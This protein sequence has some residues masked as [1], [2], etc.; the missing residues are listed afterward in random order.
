MNLTV[1]MVFTIVLIS[2]A[3]LRITANGILKQ[4]LM[5]GNILVNSIQSSLDSIFRGD[6]E[7]FHKGK[8]GWRLTRLV[9]SLSRERGFNT[10]FIFDREGRVIAH[11]E[12]G[13]EGTVF[14]DQD[15]NKA[16]SSGQII[17]KFGKGYRWFYWGVSDELVISAPIRLGLKIVGGMRANLSLKDLQESIINTQKIIFLYIVFD[18]AVIIMFGGFLLS[19]SVVRPIERLLEATDKMGGGDFSQ[20]MEDSGVNEISKLF[21]SFNRMSMRLEEHVL[22]LEGANVELKQIR[23]EVIR[24]EKL[25]S[26][27]RLAA[28]VAHEIGNPI[29]AILGYVHILL[30]GVDN[31]EEEKDYLMRI[32]AES[33]RINSIMRNLLDFSRPSDMSVKESDINRII[34]NT[35][36]ILSPQKMLQ[37]VNVDLQLGQGLPYVFVDENQLQQ[38]IINLIINATDAMPDGGDITIQT[39]ETVAIL[40]VNRSGGTLLSAR[41]KDD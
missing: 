36:S 24:S 3:T 12:E 17:T 34:E 9:H 13:M 1:L 23:D 39:K 8:E 32:E 35:I 40:G 26:V 11:N 7:A 22:S 2:I 27:G 16:I 6:P 14:Q 5:S 30:E 31:S 28:G 38:V 4:K 41:R 20:R 19:R 29:G 25:A 37:N 10:L 21:M 15:T 18:A 33:N